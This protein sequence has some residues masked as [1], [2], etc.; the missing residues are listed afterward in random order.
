MH[1]MKNPSMTTFFAV[2]QISNTATRR[3]G[4]YSDVYMH[5]G[6]IRI[7]NNDRHYSYIQIT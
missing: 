7:N 3:I 6:G 1:I 4:I 2:D 5:Y